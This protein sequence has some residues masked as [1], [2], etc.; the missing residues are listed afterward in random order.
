MTNKTYTIGDIHGRI[1]ALQQVL[2]LANFDYDNDT[3]ICL[4][5]TCDG[6]KNTKT[7][8]DELLKIKH[9]IYVLGNHDYMAYR[10][11]VLGRQLKIED[12]ETWNC[13]YYQGG[14][15][16]YKSYDRNVNNVPE[17]HRKL[18]RERSEEVV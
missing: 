11:M 10:W 15:Q 1:E 18:L 16:T 12:Y 7:C 9:L 3:L 17:S 13:W 6:G 8:F 4:G 5:D 2:K 14:I